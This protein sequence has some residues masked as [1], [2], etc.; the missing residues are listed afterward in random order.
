MAKLID[1]GHKMGE[2]KVGQADKN[3]V[4]YPSFSVDKDLGLKLGQK[5]VA[6]GTVSGIRKD[7][8]GNSTSVELR[9]MSSGKISTTDFEKMSDK[10]RE[11]YIE[12]QKP[13]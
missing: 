10:Q 9:K 13:K 2:M 6:Y 4:Y 11:D 1:L 7:K 12:K 8:Y 5:V 3:K